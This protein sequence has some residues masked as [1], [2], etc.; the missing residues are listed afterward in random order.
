MP[1]LPRHCNARRIRCGMVRGLR[2]PQ[3]PWPPD[4]N[5]TQ[6]L[7]STTPQ[8]LAQSNLH[9]KAVSK[10]FSKV[11]N[12]EFEFPTIFTLHNDIFKFQILK[13]VFL[14][15][16]FHNG[17]TRYLGH[18]RDLRRSHK[19]LLI[20]PA[21]PSCTCLPCFLFAYVAEIWA[22]GVHLRLPRERTAPFCQ[23]IPRTKFRKD[24]NAPS[25]AE[26]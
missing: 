13:T 21:A 15:S 6:K 22:P 3:E 8:K 25:S 26:W 9:R 19:K 23:R 1:A 17:P 11:K 12:F 20:V 10:R 4:R 18:T 24:S 5:V 16:E 2:R 14:N 7:D